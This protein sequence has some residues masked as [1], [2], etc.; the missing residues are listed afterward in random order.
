MTQN[1]PLQAEIS[2]YWVSKRFNKK[3]IKKLD[4]VGPVDNRASTNQFSHLKKI[5]HTGDKASLDRC[6]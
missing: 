4:G 3:K 5:P 1:G 6:G 2:K